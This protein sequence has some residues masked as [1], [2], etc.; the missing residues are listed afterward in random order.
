MEK[1]IADLEAEVA[2]LREKLAQVEQSCE[3]ATHNVQRLADKVNR[4]M[5]Q[6]HRDRLR[7]QRKEKS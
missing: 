2:F 7:E 5:L 1:R 4:R 6:E 3:D